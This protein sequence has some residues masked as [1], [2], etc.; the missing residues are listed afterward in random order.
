M[1]ALCFID[2]GVQQVEE[3]RGHLLRH[4]KAL[5]G[6]AGNALIGFVT[7]PSIYLLLPTRLM[8]IS[9]CPIRT[10]VANP[11]LRPFGSALQQWF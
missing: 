5:A 10:S 9:F 8:S 3:T 7:E 11:P 2:R 4:Q 1:K 6:V